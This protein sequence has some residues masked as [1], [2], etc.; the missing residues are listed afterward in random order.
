M[1]SEHG[2]KSPRTD[3]DSTLR[4]RLLR[5]AG[6]PVIAALTAVALVACSNTGAQEQPPTE[7]PSISAS[8]DPTEQP[9]SPDTTPTTPAA[10]EFVG[11]PSGLEVDYDAFADWDDITSFTIPGGSSLEEDTYDLRFPGSKRS[12]C[13]NFFET[14]GLEINVENGWE[15]DSNGEN[16]ATNGEEFVNSMVGRQNMILAL[17][18]DDT[19]PRNLEVSYNL[20]ECVTAPNS[21]SRQE[22]TS[23]IEGIRNGSIE[24]QNMTLQSINKYVHEQNGSVFANYTLVSPDGDTVTAQQLWTAVDSGSG[25]YRSKNYTPETEE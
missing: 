15:V 17:A 8:Q 14:N 12:I 25:L 13:Y 24:P 23:I 10:G 1:A 16:L 6:V 9:N 3:N 19:D 21:D 5:S 20:T 4:E 18:A 2:S 11:V 22:L 7:Q